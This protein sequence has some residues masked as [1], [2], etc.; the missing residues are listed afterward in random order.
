M[1]SA[2]GF[3]NEMIDNPAYGARKG[4]TPKVVVIL[5]DGQDKNPDVCILHSKRSY[6]LKFWQ[7]L[8]LNIGTTSIKIKK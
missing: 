5:T 2:L 7:S 8:K 4:N 3:L 1:A 6:T